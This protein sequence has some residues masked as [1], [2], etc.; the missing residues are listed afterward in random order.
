MPGNPT[1]NVGTDLIR[2]H[3]VMT[4]AMEVSRQ[5]S[6]ADRVAEAQQAGFTDYVHALTVLLDSHHL[7]EDELAFPFWKIRLP[8]GP[9]DRLKQQHRQMM[10]Y[11][12]QVKGWLGAPGTA[13]QPEP[14]SKLHHTLTYL[15]RL[16]L[17]HILLEEATIGP[18]NASKYLTPE[19]NGQLAQE[20]AAHGQAQ[21]EPVELVMPFIVYNLSGE[22]REEFVKL[23]PAV[24]TAQLIPIVWKARWAPMRPFLLPE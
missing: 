22:D 20:L 1:P 17:K 13:W 24:M 9:F 15:Q 6:Q 18:E 5:Y 4:R 7:G 2:I 16:W 10:A 3:K 23:M 11:I 21:S 14:R 19:E 8:E 12:G